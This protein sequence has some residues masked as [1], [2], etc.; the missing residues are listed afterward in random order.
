MNVEYCNKN[1]L[2]KNI[3]KFSGSCKDKGIQEGVVNDVDNKIMLSIEPKARTEKHIYGVAHNGKTQGEL[4]KAISSLESDN[5]MK[6]YDLCDCSA[7]VE[8]EDGISLYNANTTPDWFVQRRGREDY[9]EKNNVIKHDEW[10]KIIGGLASGLEVLHKAGIAHGDAFPYNAIVNDNNEAKW[11][12]FGNCSDDTQYLLKDVIVFFFYTLLFSLHRCDIYSKSMLDDLCEVFE[13]KNST[14]MLIDIQKAIYIERHDF[15]K[16][17]ESDDIISHVINNILVNIERIP[18]ENLK[19]ILHVLMAANDEYYNGFLFWL[20]TG[21]KYR[22]QVEFENEKFYLY[23]KEIDRLTVPKYK[24]DELK[25]QIDKINVAKKE[26][27][28]G[29][30]E[31]DVAIEEQVEREKELLNEYK[32]TVFLALNNIKKI[33][34]R[35][36]LRYWIFV[37][38]FIKK[39]VRARWKEKIALI[40]RAF[41]KVFVRRINLGIGEYS[42]LNELDYNINIIRKL[43]EQKGN[44]TLKINTKS[45]C[46]FIKNT[47]QNRIE[48]RIR[49]T[50]Y[51]LQPKV[52]VLL[53]VYNHADFIDKSIE[54]ILNQTY[55]NIELILLDDGSTDGLKEKVQEYT[56]DYR[57]HYWEQ[58]NQ[59]LPMALSHLHELASGEYVTWT[60]A[61][62]I[63]DSNMIEELVDELQHNPEISMVYGN[64]R[65]IDECG[66]PLMSE[67]YRD[68]NRNITEW[69]VLNL[70][71]DTESLGAECDNYINACFMYRRIAARALNNKYS[72]DLVGLEDYDFWL[73]MQRCGKIKH[74]NR[75]EPL[76]SYRVHKNTMSEELLTVKRQNHIERS[77][78]LMKLEKDRVLW[79]EK[80]WN[81][82]LSKINEKDNIRNILQKLPVDIESDSD[83]R[84]IFYEH[85]EKNIESTISCCVS[86]DC[87]ILNSI[88]EGNINE[89]LRIPQ[90][91]DINPL[92]L[93]ARYTNIHG[94]YYEYECVEGRFIIGMHC[95]LNSIDV[96]YL[97]D[98]IKNNKSCYFVLVNA[99]NKENKALIKA[100]EI[101]D[102]AKYLGYREYGVPYMM[103]STWN[104]ILIPKCLDV[105][106]INNVLKQYQLALNIGVWTMYDSSIKQL[107][108]KL[109]TMPIGE[110]YDF[111]DILNLSSNIDYELMSRV[112]MYYSQKHMLE[113]LLNYAN[114]TMQDI[115][116]DRPDFKVIVPTEVKPIEKKISYNLACQDF[117]SGKYIAFVVD[118]L[119]Q[120]GM[121]QVVSMLVRKLHSID[122]PVRVLCVESGGTVANELKNDGI[123]VEIFDNDKNKFMSYLKKDTPY[124]ISSHY[125]HTYTDVPHKLN[126]PVIETIHN[127]YAFYSDEQWDNEK[128]R[129]KDFDAFVAVSEMVSK[130]YAFHS[131]INDKKI[132]VIGN[133][134]EPRR[135]NRT[136][137]GIFR[138]QINASDSTFICACIASFDGRKNQLGLITAFTNFLN[139]NE[140]ADAKLVLIGNILDENYYQCCMNYI[141]D[142]GMSENIIVYPYRKNVDSVYSDVDL[143]V[144][145]SYI[146]GWSITATEAQYAAKALIHTNCGSGEEL[147]SE[148]KGI[149]I[150]NP[151]GDPLSL[152]QSVLYKKM[153]EVE[154]AN[155]EELISAIE[156]VY[157]NRDE[158]LRK[159]PA[160]R[161]FALRNFNYENMVDNY[162]DVL[163]KYVC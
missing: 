22:R 152:T 45:N 75:I 11:I 83:K 119:N 98:L 62:N 128:K 25:S 127:M 122:I 111:S 89:I 132:T 135:L 36:T 38:A 82:D 30:S 67:E 91:N 33:F 49:I 129:V 14:D 156:N 130:Y 102:N 161:T 158:W 9:F 143:I 52:S 51:Y 28:G 162:L 142:I 112:S 108:A 46:G 44:E 57:F 145:P 2:K 97:V 23:S 81:V 141:S 19:A 47:I 35:R 115:A 17:D 113:L 139:K 58:P 10:K 93:K 125:W 26:Q 32:V 20:K 8:I 76:Y 43:F 134:A 101:F 64:V 100:I 109:F 40:V 42:P 126:I 65:L 60:S 90:G 137:K 117:S 105:V 54:S 144:M 71:C 107:N 157:Q 41:A 124:V 149:L 63:M 24:Y 4:W 39:L 136:N 78:K 13:K 77:E 138:S 31:K 153:M 87:Y 66:N 159:G 16:K 74:I 106:N 50:D 73:R 3:D 69:D 155:T 86:D 133:A 99:V 29:F 123:S 114:A 151:A 61:D 55:G 85:D 96:D 84:I 18:S 160:V 95:D 6:I 80:R 37:W 5:L 12:D 121:E 1:C 131:N 79:S 94:A 148:G 116:V 103:Y 154:P 48:E 59:K 7:I 146:E 68:H 70:P 27:D 53:P 72:S 110:E 147:C 118:S 92:S 88:N 140:K 120:G 163:L 34:D 104:A 15:I 21:D 56:K 150:D